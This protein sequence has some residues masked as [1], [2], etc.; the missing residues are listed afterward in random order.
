MPDTETKWQGPCPEQCQL[1]KHPLSKATCF[2]DGRLYLRSTW[3]IMCY[4][5]HLEHGDGLGVGRGQMY[6]T[7]TLVK[8]KG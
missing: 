3:A 8:L 4:F 2:I 7:K 6:D 5:C 1:C